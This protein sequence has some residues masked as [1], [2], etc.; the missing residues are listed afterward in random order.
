MPDSA[1]MMFCWFNEDY[2]LFALETYLFNLYY[3]S[4]VSYVCKCYL[5]KYRQNTGNT[6]VQKLLP[7]RHSNSTSAS[8]PDK[9]I[10][11]SV[12]VAMG[13]LYTAIFILSIIS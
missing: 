3:L 1:N 7:S 4:I 12:F 2:W 10:F 13:I 5:L 6:L 8:S 9:I 11:Y